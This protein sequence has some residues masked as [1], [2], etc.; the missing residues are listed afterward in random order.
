M[1]SLN[2]EDDFKHDWFLYVSS[3]L[4]FLSWKFTRPIMFK[5]RIMLPLSFKI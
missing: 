3:N 2:V 1:L 4:V 5:A